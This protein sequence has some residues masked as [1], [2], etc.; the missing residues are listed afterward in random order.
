MKTI[1]INGKEFK[2]NFHQKTKHNQT[3]QLHKVVFDGHNHQGDIYKAIN[4]CEKSRILINNVLAARSTDI[5]LEMNDD[6]NTVI[7]FL[8]K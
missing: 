8:G 1:S 6:D 2:F 3:K 5:H 4:S 7:E